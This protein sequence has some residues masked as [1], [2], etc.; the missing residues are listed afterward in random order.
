MPTSRYPANTSCHCH[1]P[2][3]S[4]VQSSKK[5]SGPVPNVPPLVAP[6][7][8]R[9]LPT[10]I[11]PSAWP[12][13]QL[14]I[15]GTPLI[16]ESWLQAPR[17]TLAAALLHHLHHHLSLL[18]LLPNHPNPQEEEG[19]PV[20]VAREPAQT[21]MAI[22]PLEHPTT[23]LREKSR[24]TRPRTAKPSEFLSASLVWPRLQ[25]WLQFS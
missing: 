23:L 13:A 9:S 4:V 18:P 7:S 8:P 5:F 19:H 20:V 24:A 12:G 2:N 17:Q 16:P 25:E 14:S 21:R 6:S 15:S 3:V 1:S 10:S 22:N 11:R